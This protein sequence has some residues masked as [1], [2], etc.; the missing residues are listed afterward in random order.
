MIKIN[1]IPSEYIEKLNRKAFIAKAVVTGVVSVVLIVLLSVW[2]FTREKTL[3]IKMSR[4]QVEL[5][6]L[7][8]DVDSVKAIE[9]QI[10]EVQ[11]YL[12]SINSITRGRLIYTQFMQDILV[13]LPGTIWFGGINTALRDQTLAVTFTVNSRSAYDLAYWI[14]ALETDPKYSEVVVSAI[15]ASDNSTARVLNTTITLKYAY[16]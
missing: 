16:R 13:S 7:Q 9:G 12:D 1:L 11:R 6:G 4:L 8:A 5:K 10:S 2:Q 3:E 15:N 14:N